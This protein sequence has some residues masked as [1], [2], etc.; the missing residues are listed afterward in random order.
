IVMYTM[1]PA[2]LSIWLCLSV[3]LRARSRL[4]HATLALHLK[5]RPLDANGRDLASY[6]RITCIRELEVSDPQ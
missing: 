2:F 3:L 5:S 1:R 4:L 6:F